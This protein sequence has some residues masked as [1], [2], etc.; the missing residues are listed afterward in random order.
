MNAYL[1]L[2]HAFTVL[3]LLIFIVNWTYGHLIKPSR[4]RRAAASS[5]DTVP[6]KAAFKLISQLFSGVN[7]KA[8]A[9]LARRQMRDQGDQWVYGEIDFLGFAELLASVKPQPGETFVDCGSGAG[10]A[11]FSVALLY[12]EV[13]AVGLE[14]MPALHALSAEQFA[15]FDKLLKAN[16]IL[17]YQYQIEFLHQDLL[18]YDYHETTIVFINATCFSKQFITQFSQQIESMPSSSRVI[19]TSQKLQSAQF[20]LQNETQVVMSWGMCRVFVYLKR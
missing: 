13:K 16:A 11:V 17:P 6:K 1:T 9:N 4:A 5:L 10:K 8:I 15:L 3:I 18:L 20:Q 7:A 14:L 12:P 19:I 2:T